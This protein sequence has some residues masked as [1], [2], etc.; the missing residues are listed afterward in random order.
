VTETT[1]RAFALVG[2][3]RAGTTISLALAMAG[4]Q[5]VAVAGRHADAASTQTLAA[6]LGAPAV[7]VAD[8]ARDADLVVIA[9]PDAAIDATAH[10]LANGLCAG[11][12]VV[13]LS[14][15]RG[16]DALSG[17]ASTR[18]DVRI[19]A[20]HPL[21]TLPTTSPDAR[22]SVDSLRGAW[23][24][25]AGPD[26]VAS[27]AIDMGLAPFHVADADRPGY[28]AAAC[29][30]SNHLVALLGQVARVAADAGVPLEAFAPLV[31]SSVENAFAVGPAAALTGPVARGDVA[32]VETH[33]DALP[34]AERAAY[35]A[36]VAEALL[37]SGR[38]D[39]A[40]DALLDD[41]VPAGGMHA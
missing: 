12:L 18:S 23:A 34:E 33:L 1:R 11:A 15:A 2:P 24:A 25:V 20:L 4:H 26:E 32:T 29:V 5:P 10:A 17:L 27:L 40:L 7:E 30:A 6:R 39:P 36:L 35:R 8:V 19:G 3:G 21:Q 38:D 16:L 22:D 31:R 14:G 28:H 41:A 13:H 37:L 9:T